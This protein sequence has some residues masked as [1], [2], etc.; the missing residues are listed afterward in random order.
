MDALTTVAGPAYYIAEGSQSAL[1]NWSWA[2]AEKLPGFAVRRLR[3]AKMR[4][5][6]GLFDEFAAAL[7][8]P[9]YFGENWDALRDCLTDLMWL[10][11]KGYAVVIQDA[12]EVVSGLAAGSLA[13]FVEVLDAVRDVW[14][15]PVAVGQWWDRPAIPFSIVLHA[16]AADSE[17][18]RSA[19]GVAGKRDIQC[20]DVAGWEQGP[21]ASEL[22]ERIKEGAIKGA[23]QT[24][25]N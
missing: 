12:I 17:R 5:E 3:G 25:A 19:L 11:A 2:L 4:D 23:N 14:R 7:Q 20:I 24:S 8:F 18:L 6:Q 21:T 13:T 15:S 10:P 22:K 16:T 9:Y 1:T